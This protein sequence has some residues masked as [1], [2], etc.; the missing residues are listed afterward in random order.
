MSDQNLHERVH[1]IEIEMAHQKTTAVHTNKKLDQL[2]AKL[3]TTNEKY[4]EKLDKLATRMTIITAFV[5]GVFFVSSETG[6][7]VL[8]TLLGGM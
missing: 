5:A 3:D 7:S 1:K 4:T 8:R 6:G 2:G